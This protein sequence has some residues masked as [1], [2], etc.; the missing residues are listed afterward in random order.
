M[1]IVKPGYKIL[2]P[3]DWNYDTRMNIY[4]KIERAGRNCYKSEHKSDDA[5][6]QFVKQ[7]VKDGHMSVLEHASMQ[8]L[9]TVDRG[10]T[11]E[12]VRHRHCSF[13]QESTRYCN[14]SHGR[15]GNEVT[16]IDIRGGLGNSLSDRQVTQILNEW[17]EACEDAEDHYMNLLSTGCPPQIARSVL[18][19]S[20]KSDII[21]TA[22]MREW[23]H[24]LE[25]R[26]LGVAGK[27]H[28]QMKEVMDKLLRELAENLSALFLDIYDRQVFD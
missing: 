11:H 22:N 20:V 15:F 25:L 4:R 27:P 28:P 7:L 10:I 5:T 17:N 2:D 8:V 14:Y 21:V 3:A 24:I 6:I 19:N 18:N 26:S 16:F 13:A 9:F 1:E 23:R 12:L